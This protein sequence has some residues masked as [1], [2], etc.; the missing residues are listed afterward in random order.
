MTNVH[1]IITPQKLLGIAIIFFTGFC[2]AQGLSQHRGGIDCIS[3]AANLHRV[4]ETVLR[5]ISR[6]ESRDRDDLV[7]PSANGSY[8]LGRF[9]I[10]TTHLR[11]LSKF[12]LDVSSIMDGCTNA[13]IA[14]WLY[15]KQ[16]A[17]FG[18][19]WTAVGAY[20]SKTP[21]KRDVYALKI[22]QLVQQMGGAR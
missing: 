15:S 13:Y 1:K 11:E 10:N 19:T 21:T 5:A 6:H 7:V 17:R 18:N 22:Q 20:H 3:D 12:G 8:D 16:V 14:A 9:G 2:S 4:N